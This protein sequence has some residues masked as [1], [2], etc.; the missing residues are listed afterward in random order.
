MCVLF[1][2]MLTRTC[3]VYFLAKIV[4]LILPPVPVYGV[5]LVYLS[6]WLYL[7]TYRTSTLFWVI[8]PSSCL[9]ACT[10]VYC[11]LV[12]IGTLP[13]PLPQASVPPPPEPQGHTR[14]RVRGF[15][16]RTKVYRPMFFAKTSP[17][18]S[19]SVIENDRL[20]L[21]FAKTGS[22]NLGT[23]LEKKLSTLS[24]LYPPACPPTFLRLLLPFRKSFGHVRPI[25]CRLVPLPAFLYPVCGSVFL[26]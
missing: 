23:V 16:I 3:A 13:P 18:R 6:R 10:T 20:G 4:H 5:A 11:P 12:R 14:L 15:P 22:I 25:A 26:Y 24:T 9:S 17:T 19:F 8:L 21:V 7:C 1:K 2:K